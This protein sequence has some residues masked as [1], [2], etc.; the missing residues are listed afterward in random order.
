M[1]LNKHQKVWIDRL[2][3]GKTRKYKGAL[4]APKSNAFCCLGVACKLAGDDINTELDLAGHDEVYESLRLRSLVGEIDVKL[5]KPKWKWI[6]EPYKDNWGCEQYSSI[7]LA[8]LNDSA[9]GIS[10]KVIGEFIDQNRKA[11]FHG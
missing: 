3:S 1:R 5:V 10:H 6:L 11:V 9:K 7:A 8:D 4:K 2:K